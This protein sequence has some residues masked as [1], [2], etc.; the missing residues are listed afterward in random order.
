MPKGT[1]QPKTCWYAMEP[2]PPINAANAAEDEDDDDD[3]DDHASTDSGGAVSVATTRRIS[4]LASDRSAAL[5]KATAGAS[6]KRKRR[7][8]SEGPL[9]A[10]CDPAPPLP[11]FFSSIL[12]P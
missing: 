3:D 10:R 6:R 12:S 2:L 1:A 4:P 8:S 11:V 7:A 5:T 9:I